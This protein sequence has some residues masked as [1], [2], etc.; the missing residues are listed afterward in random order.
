M[1]LK[2]IIKGKVLILGVD[3]LP[4]TLTED[5]PK[6]FVY[7]NIEY[8]IKD[9][10]CRATALGTRT[11]QTANQLKEFKPTILVPDI[12]YPGEQYIANIEFT[13]KSYDYKKATFNYSEELDEYIKEHDTIIF[14]MIGGIG[15]KN[16]WKV[17][18]DK[19]VIYD[20]F[21]N[22]LLSLPYALQNKDEKYKEDYSRNYKYHYN[23][24]FERIDYI[25]YCNE[26]MR[27]F[28]ESQ[29][30]LNGKLGYNNFKESPLIKFPYT[31]ENRDLKINREKVV[32][33]NNKLIV[34]SSLKLLW[35]GPSY[36]WYD[37]E[38]LIDVIGTTDNVTLDFVAVKHP[39]YKNSYNE[40]LFK[41]L[42]H[43]IKVIEEYQDERWEIYKNYDAGILLSKE[44]VENKYNTRCRLYD[45][46]SYGLPIITNESTP[47]FKELEMEKCYYNLKKVIVERTIFNGM[48]KLSI[49]W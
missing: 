44:Y 13:I 8:D 9:K 4:L 46:L 15:A 45:M 22:Q 11:W 23:L 40:S 48:K 14:P 7:D 16:F 36:P 5:A 47:I 6:T 20:G 1:N 42:P 18:E 3:T 29:L 24:N 32:V 25:L 31:L 43:N 39:R 21:E 26:P 38:T 30:Y 37:I 12:N 10:C 27:Y 33:K 49:E 28:F 35:Y 2:D 41:D 17:P 19:V 34:D